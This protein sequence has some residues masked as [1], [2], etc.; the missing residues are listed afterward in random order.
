M[1]RFCEGPGLGPVAGVPV[2]GVEVVPVAG[3]AESSASFGTLIAE[4]EPSQD[5]FKIR[6]G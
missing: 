4:Q 5:Y 3:R 6:R 1:V 2:K